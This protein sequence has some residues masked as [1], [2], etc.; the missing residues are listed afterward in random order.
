MLSICEY[1]ASEARGFVLSVFSAR[2]GGQV[3]PLDL[4]RVVARIAAI[5]AAERHNAETWACSEAMTVAT[6][7]AVY[8]PDN[9]PR[10]RKPGESV[11]EYRAAMGW[12]AKTDSQDLD[13]VPV[14]ITFFSDYLI[15]EPAPMSAATEAARATVHAVRHLR[16]RCGAFS[17]RRYAE[18]R[19]ASRGMYQAAEEF[20]DRR[21][22]RRRLD[23]AWLDYGRL[24]AACSESRK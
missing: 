2:A 9:P 17:A 24:P 1:R 4:L 16:K 11:D 23:D 20:E 22:L 18:L 3:V 12:G 21:D 5:D 13:A 7:K 8:G 14:P 6:E 15:S 19:G 10:L